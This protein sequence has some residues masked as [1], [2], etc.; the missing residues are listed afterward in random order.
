MFST[1]L[2]LGLTACGSHL[3]AVRAGLPQGLEWLPKKEK[4]SGHDGPEAC[5]FMV[6]KKLGMRSRRNVSACGQSSTHYESLPSVHEST[7]EIDAS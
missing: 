5:T 6:V 4:T 1:A 7:P 3:L 2:R